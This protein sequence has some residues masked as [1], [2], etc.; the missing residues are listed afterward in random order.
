[1]ETAPDYPTAR[2]WLQSSSLANSAWGTEHWAPYM[3][4]TAMRI[5]QKWK[6]G[7]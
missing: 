6:S 2:H 4:D 5:A 3:L 1:L 7:F